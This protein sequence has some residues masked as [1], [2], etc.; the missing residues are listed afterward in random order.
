MPA[1]SSKIRKVPGGKVGPDGVGAPEFATGAASPSPPERPAIRPTTRTRTSPSTDST[2]TQA[3]GKRGAGAA[4][5]GAAAGRGGAAAGG[6]WTVT[7]GPAGGGTSDHPAP[8]HHR[9]RPPAPSG[10]GYQPGGGLAPPGPLMPA[11]WVPVGPGSSPR[12]Q[13]VDGGR[14]SAGGDAGQLPPQVGGGLR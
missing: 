1:S 2:T 13:P 8:S 4:A 7:P 5:G 6:R 9:T 3:V 12:A 11:L 14:S 10:S